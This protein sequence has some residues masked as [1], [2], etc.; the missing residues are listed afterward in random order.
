MRVLGLDYGS[1]TCGVAVS[2]PLGI[3]AS[4]LETIRYNTL[5]ELLDRLNTIIKE[6][7]VDI[8]VLGNPLNLDGSISKRSEETF[9]FKEILID[10][11]HLNVILEDERLTSVIVNNMLKEN[12]M[13]T[14]SRRKVV[15]KLAATLILES[16]LDR[17]NNGK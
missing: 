10:K 13:K 1:K 9:K 8:L 15:D 16:Y 14:T 4:P 3:V 7:K 11:F 2:D 6:Y 5:E 17:S 12:N